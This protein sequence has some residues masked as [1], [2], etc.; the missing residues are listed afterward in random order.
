[1]QQNN[2]TVSADYIRK[3]FNYLGIQSKTR[4]KAHRK[5]RKIKD[6]YPNLVFSTWETIDR[7][8]QVIVSDMTAFWT[9]MAYWELT[10]Y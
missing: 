9:R 6:P 5:P 4:H 10:L 8:R 7:P 2:I 3:A 1:L